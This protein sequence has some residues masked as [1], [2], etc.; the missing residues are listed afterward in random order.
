MKIDLSENQI[1]HEIGNI[2]HQI[3]V[4]TEIISTDQNRCENVM[5][6]QK[7][8]YKLDSLIRVDDNINNLSEPIRT[9][10]AE[11]IKNKIRNKKILIVDDILDNSVFLEKI[12]ST[13]R[14]QV[15]CA[16]DGYEALELVKSFHPDI[17]CMDIVMPGMDGFETARQLKLSGYKGILIGVSALRNYTDEESN[18]MSRWL[19][20]PFTI[21][22]LLTILENIHIENL[23]PEE[24]KNIFEKVVE[25]P[26]NLY[27]QLIH[28]IDAGALSEAEYFID[29]LPVSVDI[30]GHL[31]QL[32]STL[33]FEQLKCIINPA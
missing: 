10:K 28:L 17:I 6:I 31:M 26:E 14:C 15:R 16:K 13:L 23:S 9:S 5:A 11:I 3:V 1:S 25:L 4:Y 21:N 12:F 19:Y 7:L 27:A 22:D 18:L 32:C 2:L 24:R 30:K 33:Q 20:K 8:C 29:E